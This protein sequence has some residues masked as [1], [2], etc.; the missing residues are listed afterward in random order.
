VEALE[1]A[2]TA[3]DMPVVAQ[4]AIGSAA[5][6]AARGA[7]VTAAEMIGVARRLAGGDDRS[8]V[9]LRRQSAALEEALGV[10]G[11]ADAVRRG[12]ALDRAAAMARIEP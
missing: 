2:V 4:I 8:N 10:D 11:F 9:D 6:A 7:P 1:L 12:A 5:L 3:R